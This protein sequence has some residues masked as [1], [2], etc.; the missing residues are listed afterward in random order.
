MDLQSQLYAAAVK[1][2]H[3]G[4]PQLLDLLIPGFHLFLRGLGEGVPEFPD[5]RAHEECHRVHAHGL[6]R[7]SG[8]FHLLHGPGLDGLRI[9]GVLGG[10]EAVQPGVVGAG[11]GVAHALARQVIADGPAAKAV[12][13]Q[14]VLDLLD[15]GLVGSGPLH[16]QM[17][18]GELE[19]LIAHFL[20]QGADLLQGEIAP[21]NG[22]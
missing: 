9:A 4:A 18:G 1:L 17:G 21:L 3:D 20:R 15:I 14:C 12:F 8:V 7:L 16:V 6:G 5:G 2:V 10:G 13:C 22:K 11:E 19:T